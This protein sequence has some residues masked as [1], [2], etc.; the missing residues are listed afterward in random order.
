MFSR[1][2]MLVMRPVL[3]RSSESDKYRE[4]SHC[5]AIEFLPLFRR[6][7]FPPERSNDPKTVIA[8]SERP[9]PTRPARPSTSP[10]RISK[11]IQWLGK[12]RDEVSKLDPLFRVA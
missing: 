12:R 5:A 8:S 1:S 7:D 3:R 4:R 6:Y 9:T 11:E 2:A 10:R